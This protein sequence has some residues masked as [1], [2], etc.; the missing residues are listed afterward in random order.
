MRTIAL[1]GSALLIVLITACSSPLT[2]Q[3]RTGFFKAYNRLEKVSIDNISY[4]EK[5]EDANLSRY[6]KIVIPEIKVLSNSVGQTPQENELYTLVSAYTTAAYRKS[7]IKKSSN[8]ALV[9]VAQ[10]DSMIMQIALSMVEVHPEEKSWD[11]LSALAFSINPSTYLTY[12]EGNARLLVEARITD[13][14]SG[15]VLARSMRVV[16]EE[17]IRLHNDR[18][19]FTDLQAALDRW[20]NEA[21]IKHQ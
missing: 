3:N 4:F 2:Y 17:E 11:N 13:A 16:M 15:K 7:I 9:D 21:V 5:S 12:Q 1:S 10:K 14:M 6:N 20:L 18:L 8:Y 19:E